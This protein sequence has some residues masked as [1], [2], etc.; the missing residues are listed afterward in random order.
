MNKNI[1]TLQKVL[2]KQ[3]VL[4]EDMVAMFI[5]CS[6][7]SN[8]KI[9]EPEKVPSLIQMLYQ[10]GNVNNLINYCINAYV[11]AKKVTA[12]YIYNKNG[13]LVKVFVDERS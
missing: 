7:L 10:S 2:E 4:M 11:N 8:R 9:S 6:E 1:Q 5:E 3:S 13:K 12:C